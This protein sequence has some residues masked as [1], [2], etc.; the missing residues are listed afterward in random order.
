MNSSQNLPAAPSTPSI[1]HFFLTSADLLLGVPQ[2]E[3][4]V[5]KFSQFIEEPQRPQDLLDS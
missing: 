4:E 1:P 3:E 2:T 5:V